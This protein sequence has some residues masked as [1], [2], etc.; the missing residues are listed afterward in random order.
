M[1]STI[2]PTH[3]PVTH[4]HVASLRPWEDV[5]GAKIS[6]VLEA[7]PFADGE[8][9]ANAY[10]LIDSKGTNICAS[11]QAGTISI[12]LPKEWD[13]A[14]KK[15]LQTLIT[16]SA[17]GPISHTEKV[18]KLALQHLR[19]QETPARTYEEIVYEAERARKL[20]VLLTALA[21]YVQK[22]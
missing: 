10:V 1:I 17:L 5:R 21:D 9:S 12:P 7:L 22:A 15:R 13:D 11:S 16:K 14:S 6:H 18:E 19:R 4:A 3:A 2:N 8:S 20:E